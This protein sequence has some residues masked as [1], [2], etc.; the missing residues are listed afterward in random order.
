MEWEKFFASNGERPEVWCLAV[1][2]LSK[3]DLLKSIGRYLAQ[4]NSRTRF[5]VHNARDM[6]FVLKL[7]QEQL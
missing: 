3:E 7:W 1:G 5:E 2:N 6:E 4:Y